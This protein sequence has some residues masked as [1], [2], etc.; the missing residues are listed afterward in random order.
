[1]GNNSNAT[2]HLTISPVHHGDKKAEKLQSITYQNL[3]TNTMY[4]NN[5]LANLHK[6]GASLGMT[7]S[8]NGR[9]V[10]QTM[11]QCLMTEKFILVVSY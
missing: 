9:E 10:H 11:W 6:D 3:D 2:I 4:Q 8:Y 5:D 1:M 7:K